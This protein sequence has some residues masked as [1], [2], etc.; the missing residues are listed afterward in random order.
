[1]WLLFLG[2][3]TWRL[4]STVAKT[5]SPLR[6][7]LRKQGK[8]YDMYS[9]YSYPSWLEM[10]TNMH[11]NSLHSLGSAR[12]VLGLLVKDEDDAEAVAG[13]Q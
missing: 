10:I 6:K 13:F 5:Y 4:Q 7:L 8:C 1:M 9:H 12:N 11:V 2:L 3:E